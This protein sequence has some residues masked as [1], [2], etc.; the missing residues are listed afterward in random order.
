MKPKTAGRVKGESLFAGQLVRTSSRFS[1]LVS[2]AR[3]FT[4]NGERCVRD[5]RVGDRLITRQGM[6]PIKKIET[7][8][9]VTRAIY[10]L[11]GSLGHNRADRDCLLCEDQTVLLRDWRAQA[12]GKAAEILIPARDLIDGE[13]VRDLGLQPMTLYRLFCDRPQVIYSDGMELGSADA[14]NAQTTWRAA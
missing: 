12:F 13:F 6:V 8:S 3:T 14:I 1:G 2:G 4:S 10:V 9:V 7:V 11:A 5:L